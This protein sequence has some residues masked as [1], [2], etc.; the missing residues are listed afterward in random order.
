MSVKK[1]CLL[2]V[3]VLA[4]LPLSS[5]NRNN[6]KSEEWR[7]KMIEQKRL[8]VISKMDLSEAETVAFTVL[9]NQYEAD[10]HASHRVVRAAF[11]AVD[12]DYTEGEY[13]IFLQTIQEEDLRQAAI[14]SDFFDSLK[15]I[16]PASKIY[17]FCTADHEFNRLLIK[18][19][20]KKANEKAK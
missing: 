9:Y 5:E 7:A 8:Y 12:S 13:E 19:V 4:V 17:K 16:M 10:I 11:K 14:R 3:A 15:K 20:D 6:R 1:Y 2:I 18:D